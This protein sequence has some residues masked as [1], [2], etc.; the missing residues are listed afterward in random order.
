MHIVNKIDF[1][2]FK[3]INMNT[4]EF[5]FQEFYHRNPLP[6]GLPVFVC[7]QFSQFC[8]DGEGPMLVRHLHT[9]PPH[10][11]LCKHYL[12]YMSSQQILN[13]YSYTF[14]RQIL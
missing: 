6:T 2:V 11:Y 1:E 3:R 5:Q 8:S 13:E 14:L 10:C 12:L 4:T 7:S 9:R